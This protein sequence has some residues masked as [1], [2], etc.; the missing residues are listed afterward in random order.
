MSELCLALKHC[1]D[2]TPDANGSGSIFR[3][4]NATDFVG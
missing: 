1:F 3:F 4:A 2:D